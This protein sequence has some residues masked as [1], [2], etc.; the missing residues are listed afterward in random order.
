MATNGDQSSREQ[1]MEQTDF[2]VYAGIIAAPIAVVVLSRVT[3]WS[4]WLT[5]PIGAVGGFLATTIAIYVLIGL[6]GKHAE[7]K[8]DE[9]VK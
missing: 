8:T 1:E 9:K 6:I 5:A 7:K 3:G 4:Y 2:A